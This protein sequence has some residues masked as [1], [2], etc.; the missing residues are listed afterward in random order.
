V[1]IARVA[2]WYFFKP[3]SQFGSILEGLTME[4][5][6]IFYGDLEYFTAI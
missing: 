2:R 6:G 4:N 5:V 1:I 3:K